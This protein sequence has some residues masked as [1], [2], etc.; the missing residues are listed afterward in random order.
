MKLTVSVACSVTDRST[1]ILDGRIKI[2]GCSVIPMPG[3]TQDIF[4]RTLNDQAF[5]IAE[6]SMSS[7]IVTTARDN[8]AYIGVPIFL[9]RS[10]RHSSIYIRS[11]RGISRPEDLAGRTIGLDQYQQT[12]ALWARGILR[13]RHG[14]QP[15]DVKWRT[16][17]LEQPGGGERVALKLPATIDLQSIPQG[18]TLNGMLAAGELD[19]VISPRPPSSF[20]LPEK[21][22]SRLFPDYRTAEVE[23]FKA[24]G[25][26][27]IMHLVVI[28]RSLVER[29]PWL[30]AEVFNAF[31]KAKAEALNNLTLM[32]IPRVSLAWVVDQADETRQ[33]LGQKMW[34]YGLEESR[35]ELETMLR[36]S[37]ADG[38]IAAQMA[39][40]ALFH[41]STHKL[42]DAAKQ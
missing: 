21:I 22:V 23:Y 25:I 31:A 14:V 38:L 39:P 42:P 28:R 27:P 20:R 30:A 17:G 8:S 41:P 29:H 1:P 4:R 19:A 33:I 26:F 34:A 11:D 2:N 10:F 18:Q 24:T 32:N 36:Y 16:G 13:D 37:H 35:V 5:D 9:S 15:E 6:M 3:E 40:E 12:V 7:H